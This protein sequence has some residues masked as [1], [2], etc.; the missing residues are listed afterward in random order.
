MC[1]TCIGCLLLVCALLADVCVSSC[2]HCAQGIAADICACLPNWRFER[3]EF[4]IAAANSLARSAHTTTLYNV[5]RQLTALQ[6]HGAALLGVQW[7]EWGWTDAI[8]RDA[9]AVSP[10]LQQFQFSFN[11]NMLSDELLG[12]VIA[13]RPR[14]HTV[15]VQGM[16]R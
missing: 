15:R 6:A 9:A 14:V 8:A 16:V 3:S 13:T 1:P 4:H 11:D 10:N 2:G 5:F 12:V 7:A